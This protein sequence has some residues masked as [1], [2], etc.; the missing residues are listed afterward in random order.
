MDPTGF[1]KTALEL[2]PLAGIP[3]STPA[4]MIVTLW[5]IVS[6]FCGMAIALFRLTSVF[7][8]EGPKD[9]PAKVYLTVMIL[10]AS[11]SW[12][13][14]AIN[15]AQEDAKFFDAPTVTVGAIRTVAITPSCF[16][17][18]NAMNIV[19]ADGTGLAVKATEPLQ[20][21]DVISRKTIDGT[22]R[23]FVADNNVRPKYL[24]TF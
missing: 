6:S 19:L 13:A 1:S 2:Y 9:F 4:A 18:E 7:T 14:L 21:G 23:Y 12:A 5:G 16:A 8:D 22:N 24:E 3:L 20:A 17:C 15:K 11:M 10:G